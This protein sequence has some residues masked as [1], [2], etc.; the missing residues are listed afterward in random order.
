MA[1]KIFIVEMTA[2][3]EVEVGDLKEDELKDSDELMKEV[4]KATLAFLQEQ[5]LDD[6]IV[7]VENYYLE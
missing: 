1:R 7:L 4:H 2:E 5:T 3:V 6:M